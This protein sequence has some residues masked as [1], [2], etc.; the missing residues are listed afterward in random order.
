MAVAAWA[1]TLQMEV[2]S[3][4]V[5]RNAAVYI[6]SP[7]CPV[8]NEC[9]SILDIDLVQPMW[10]FGQL[11]CYRDCDV[12]V[13]RAL[14]TNAA[15]C[16]LLFGRSSGIGAANLYIV[17]VEVQTLLTKLKLLCTLALGSKGFVV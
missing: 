1:R 16:L 14:K 9:W 4:R 2:R 8:E 15:T 7:V 6:S 5:R 11:Q 3:I 10:L 12:I 13:P 17:N